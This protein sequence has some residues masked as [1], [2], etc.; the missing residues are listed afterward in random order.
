M[1]HL[2]FSVACNLETWFA[3]HGAIL[4]RNLTRWDGGQGVW[5]LKT[6]LLSPPPG[7]ER[8]GLWMRLCWVLLKVRVLCVGWWGGNHSLTGWIAPV[9]LRQHISDAKKW[10][11]LCAVVV[12]VLTGLWGNSVESLGA[13]AGQSGLQCSQADTGHFSLHTSGVS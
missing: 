8:V 12:L 13:R 10:C 2:P 4:I 5:S 6:T 3:I 11:L 9:Y 1:Y 7:P